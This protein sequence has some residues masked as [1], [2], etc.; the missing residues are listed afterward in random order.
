MPS[1]LS[2][3]FIGLPAYAWLIGGVVTIGAILYFMRRSS[4]APASGTTSSNATGTPQPTVVPY[5]ISGGNTNPTSS[6]QFGSLME[7]QSIWGQGGGVWV[8]GGP[9]EKSVVGVAPDKTDYQSTGPAV[10]GGSHYANQVTSSEWVP[11]KWGDNTGYLW[12]PEARP[13]QQPGSAITTQSMQVGTSVAPV[14]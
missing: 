8:F 14:V 9:D 10:M 1:W 13:I 11:I 4:G 3:S 2:K 7:T 12:G 6:Q 5:P